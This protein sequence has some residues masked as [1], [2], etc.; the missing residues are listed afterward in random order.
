[1]C[2]A[3][4]NHF[5]CGCSRPNAA[6]LQQCEHAKLKGEACPEFMITEDKSQSKTYDLLACMAHS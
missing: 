4:Y 1:M 6:T 2:T 5:N 3:G